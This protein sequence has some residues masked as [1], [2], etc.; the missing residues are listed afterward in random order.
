MH[1]STY[2]S[3]FLCL[4]QTPNVNSS[5][6]TANKLIHPNFRTLKADV[7]MTLTANN[8]NEKLSRYKILN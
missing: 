2:Q 6:D 1:T 4:Y 5:D 8:N 3:C 7:T